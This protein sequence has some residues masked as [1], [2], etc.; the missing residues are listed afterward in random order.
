MFKIYWK[1]KL[2]RPPLYLDFKSKNEEINNTTNSKP[3]LQKKII[4]NNLESYF[5]LYSGDYYFEKSV[6][7]DVSIY[8]RKR[9]K[10]YFFWRRNFLVQTGI[11][12]IASGDDILI[13]EMNPRI[14][15]NWIILL[16]RRISQKKPF[17]GDTPGPGLETLKKEIK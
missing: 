14:I 15:T 4:K 5:E 3:G 13:L 17:F 2:L 8:F 7:S 12:S 1:S 6:K 16:Y 10:N 9:V 11:W